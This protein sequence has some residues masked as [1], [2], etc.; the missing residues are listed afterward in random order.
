MRAGTSLPLPA[1]IGTA[2]SSALAQDRAVPWLFWLGAVLLG[3]AL[4]AR[5]DLHTAAATQ[6]GMLLMLVGGLPH[7]G[8]DLLVAKRRWGMKGSALALFLAAYSAVAAAMALTWWIAPLLALL[9]FLGLAAWHFSE[10][11][12]VPQDGLLRSAAGLAPIA[13]AVLGQP[14][15]VSALFAAMTDPPTA[16]HAVALV[17]LVAPVALLVAAVAIATAWQTGSRRWAAAQ[18]TALVLLAT[19]PPTIAFP[20]YFALLHSRR[21]IVAIFD[22]FGT[23][24][25]GHGPPALLAAALAGIACAGWAAF[26]PGFVDLAHGIDPAL[27][28]QLFSVVA[29]PHLLFEA[30]GTRLRADMGDRGAHAA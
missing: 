14:R 22:E 28:F 11:W 9:A 26:S 29:A 27:A 13:A 4:I 16:R 20:L 2:R 24:A 6:A 1:A 30:M 23:S 10:D 7:G 15:A 3:L 8:H 17:T 18:G 12:D 19:A 25:V 21:H 5:I